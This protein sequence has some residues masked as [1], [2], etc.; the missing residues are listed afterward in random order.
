MAEPRPG[1]GVSQ[2]VLLDIGDDVGALVVHA[3]KA[4]LGRE[5]EVSPAGGGTRRVHAVVHQRRAG[6]QPLFAAVFPALAHGGYLLWDGER[7]LGRV[8]ITGGQVTE[9]TWPACGL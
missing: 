1:A 4:L 8:K 3:P 7:T 9:L 2:G 5:V 6:G